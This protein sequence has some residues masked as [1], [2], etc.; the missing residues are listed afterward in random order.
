MAV[1]PYVGPCVW[2]RAGHAAIPAAKDH[3][4]PY[5]SPF[6]VPTLREG[7]GMLGPNL[8]RAQHVRTA[9]G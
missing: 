1:L 3:L 8:G 9:W 7:G 4:H 6:H 5:K 2:P